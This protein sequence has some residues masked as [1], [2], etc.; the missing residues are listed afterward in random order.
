MVP[1]DQRDVARLRDVATP[2]AHVVTTSADEPLASLL[3][4]LAVWPRVPAAVHTAG[5]ALVL[6][7]DGGLAGLITPADLSLAT[8]RGSLRRRT[9]HHADQ[10]A[11]HRASH[12]TGACPGRQASLHTGEYHTAAG[13]PR[14]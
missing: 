5:Y 10:R 11:G 2:L 6:N 8:Q 9:G 14:L 4:R 3:G 1:E 7:P 13:P 12:D